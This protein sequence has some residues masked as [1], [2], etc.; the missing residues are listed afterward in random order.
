MGTTNTDEINHNPLETT[1]VERQDDV[2]DAESRIRAIPDAG[3][4]FHEDR[5]MTAHF[6]ETPSRFLRSEGGRM[7]TRDIVARFK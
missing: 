4:R 6:D 5:V 3:N 1:H 2:G 7:G